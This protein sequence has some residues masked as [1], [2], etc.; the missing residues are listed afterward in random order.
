[1]GVAPESMS[2]VLTI[3]HILKELFSPQAVMRAMYEYG[4][5]LVT[6]ESEVDRLRQELGSSKSTYLSSVFIIFCFNL[7]LVD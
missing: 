3:G 4:R 1:M 5:R 6:A 2:D 7:H